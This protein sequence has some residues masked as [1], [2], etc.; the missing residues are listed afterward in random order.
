MPLKWKKQTKHLKREVF[1]KTSRLTQGS[2]KHSEQEVGS[3]GS[4]PFSH[5]P[6]N[7]P[8]RFW[9][10]RVKPGQ[11]LSLNLLGVTGLLSPSQFH[12]SCCLGGKKRE[13]SGSVLA[14]LPQ[15]RRNYQLCLQAQ[16]GAAPLRPSARW[17]SLS[18]PDF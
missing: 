7:L 13:Q 6:W 11:R 15:K 3:L 14:P 9:E 12:V 2:N 10:S 18:C 5:L 16:P 1:R 17:E 8:R 4:T